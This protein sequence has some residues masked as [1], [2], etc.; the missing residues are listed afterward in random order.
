MKTKLFRSLLIVLSAPMLAFGNSDVSGGAAAVE[1]FVVCAFANG[2]RVSGPIQAL[3]PEVF[4]LKTEYA[5]IV[6]IKPAS[7]VACE[8]SEAR[9]QARLNELIAAARANSTNNV[10]FAAAPA[11]TAA[12]PAPPPIPESTW[13][14]TLA[15]SYNL[16]R[17]NADINDMNLAGG[18]EYQ[19][20][21][22]KLIIQSLVR[23]GTKNGQDLAGLFTSTARYERNLDKAFLASEKVT[24]FNEFNYEKDVMKKLDHRLV[25]NG[26]VLLPLY[27]K[28]SNELALDLGGGLTRE[29]YATDVQRTLGSG[30]IRLK[31]EQKILGS[32]RLTQQ[33]A[34]FPDFAEVGRYRLYADVSVTAP[35]TRIFSVRIGALNRFDNRP[36]EAVKRNDFSLLS[37]L[38][39]SF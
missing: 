11:P 6:A 22:S 26:G 1:P 33:L 35:L 14:R 19:E 37:G 5:G 10:E 29:V 7:V 39:V 28:E 3:T 2:D 17:G 36:Q 23:R 30:L 18:V 16:S 31:S 21:D 12:A 4:H 24:L 20:P 32:T 8:T 27:K 38:A 25:W 9:T 15:F 13:K 34:A